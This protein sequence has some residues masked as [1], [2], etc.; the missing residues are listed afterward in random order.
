MLAPQC[1]F[2]IDLKPT[3]HLDIQEALEEGSLCEAKMH[4]N[5]LPF[6]LIVTGLEVWVLFFLIGAG[7]FPSIIPLCPIHTNVHV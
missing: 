5:R 7:Y 4:S 2:A 3:P 1:M 6:L